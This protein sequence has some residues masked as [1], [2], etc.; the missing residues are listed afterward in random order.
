MSKRE[1]VGEMTCNIFCFLLGKAKIF[2][3]FTLVATIT[4]SRE[5]CS[6]NPNNVIF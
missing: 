6:E 2:K 4:Q 1:E 5:A 3:K